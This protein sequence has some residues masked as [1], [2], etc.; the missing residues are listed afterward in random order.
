MRVGRNLPIP[1]AVRISVDGDGRKVVPMAGI[2][3]W[4]WRFTALP[5]KPRF[6]AA[7]IPLILILAYLMG[8]FFLAP[9]PLESISADASSVKITEGRFGLAAADQ[10]AGGRE[11]QAAAAPSVAR[12]QPSDTD[13]RKILY[14]AS[15][16]LK[17]ESAVRTAATLG[18]MAREYGGY[19]QSSST[20]TLDKGDHCA[21]LVLRIPA[22]GFQAFL[23][24]AGGLGR[25]ERRDVAGQDVTEDYVDQ[26]ARLRAWEGEEQ[27]LMVLMARAGTVGEVLA[28]RE[29]LS[30]VRETIEQLQGR[31]RYYDHH[32]AMATVNISLFERAGS[33]P[34]SAFLRELA[35]MG[36]ALYASCRLLILAILGSIPW[37]LAGWGLWRLGKRIRKSRGEASAPK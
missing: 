2:A 31:L 25:V 26:A 36:R 10:A 29:R 20:A 5:G 30:Q 23:D 32:V 21:E 28:V 3:H 19:V 27:Q 17:V 8:R 18:R 16:R 14:T 35:E 9:A 11:A 22:E 7:L 33:G 6:W 4:R 1:V 37:F 15:L 12:E 13:A 24:A 34:P